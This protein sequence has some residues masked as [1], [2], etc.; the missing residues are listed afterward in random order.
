[1][2]VSGKIKTIRELLARNRQA[3]RIERESKGFYA[4][5]AQHGFRLD[6]ML[7]NHQAVFTLS[8]GRCG[9]LQLADLLELSDDCHVYHHA[10]PELVLA[11]RYAYESAESQSPE[12][13]RLALLAA[14]GERII[15][16]YKGKRRYVETNRYLTFFAHGLQDL[17]P[18]ARFIHLVRNPKDFIRSGLARRYYA[19]A[20]WNAVNIHPDITLP[21]A[22]DPQALRVQRIAALWLETNRFIESFKASAPE[23]TCRMIRA[24]DLFEDPATTQSLYTFL[25]LPAPDAATIARLL[26]RPRNATAPS[27]KIDSYP[28]GSLAGYT[29]FCE[30]AEQYGY[31]TNWISASGD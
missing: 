24:E 28:A 15:E 9:T 17:L 27:Q 2:S 7:E 11:N 4:G 14:R 13:L 25:G 12:G 29:D 21:E 19:H 1:M 16:A 20:F 8:T 23:G 26:R 6:D 18:E 3:L 22:D 10:E 30:L 5:E 31:A